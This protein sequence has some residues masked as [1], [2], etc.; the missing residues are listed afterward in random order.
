MKEIKRKNVN[1]RQAHMFINEQG[2]KPEPL[3]PRAAKLEP[4]PGNPYNPNNPNKPDNSHNPNKPNN[5]N[6]SN[7]SNSLNYPNNSNN[8]TLGSESM[9]LEAP[10]PKA[11][12]RLIRVA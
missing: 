8:S 2:G 7:N 5:P 11:V 3:S 6:N 4:A 1:L 10:P 12:I 9:P